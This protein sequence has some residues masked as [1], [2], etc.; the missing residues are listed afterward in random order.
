[1]SNDPDLPAEPQRPPL[2]AQPSPALTVGL[3]ALFLLAIGC[4]LLVGNVFENYENGSN[5]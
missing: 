5:L 2:H 1:M 3:V 4:G